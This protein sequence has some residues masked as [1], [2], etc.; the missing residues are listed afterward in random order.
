M[1]S[2]VTLPIIIFTVLISIPAF[3]NPTIL[4]KLIFD[5]Y[6]I[7]R[8]RDWFKFISSGFL[9]ADFMHLGVNMYVLY[10]FGP[11][12]EHYYNVNFGTK[13]MV[14]FM[15]LY[16]S[17]IAA[18]NIS[19]YFK[20]QNNPNYRALGASGAV[21]AILFASVL[22]DPKSE[23]R[24]YFSID[25][26]AYIAAGLYL[27]Y[28]HFASGRTKDNVNHE[29]HFYGALYGVAFTLLCKPSLLQEFINKF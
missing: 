28:S 10:S 23:W 17:S 16:I 12:V 1:F 8:N 2:G 3:T 18:A 29:A 15:V 24:L 20:E 11:V 14:L 5:P 7:K 9:H 19:T 22:F 27:V 21:S 25:I 26:P 4:N 13:G 6:E